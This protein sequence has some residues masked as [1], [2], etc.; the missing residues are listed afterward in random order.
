M[1]LGLLP[2]AVLCAT[3]TYASTTPS[4]TIVKRDSNS[5]PFVT[6]ADGQFQANGSEIKFVGTNAYWLSTLNTDADIDNT[7]ASIAAIGIKVVRLWAFNDV[8]TI[9]V[10]G[11]WLQLVLK[12]GT[13]LFNTGPNGIQKLDKILE[14][15]PQ[16]GLFVILSLT[17]NWNPLPLL[18]PVTTPTRRDVTQGTN[19]TL[20]R[21]FLSNDY[22]GMDLYIRQLGV[23]LTHDQFYTDQT[24]IDAFENYI[25]QIVSRYANNP[26][27][28]S[29]EI[30]N[31]PRCNS[32][33]AASS[34]CTTTTITQW[35]SIIA[36]HIR[37]IDPNHLISSGTGGFFC[38]SCPKLFPPTAP[39]PAP[40][41]S[42]VPGVTRRRRD[43]L[44]RNKVLE[45]AQLRKRNREA[46]KRAGGLSQNGI[47]I[48]G[49]WLSTP[50]RR[51]D[52]GVGPAFDGSSGVDSEDIAG[53]PEVGFLT[54]QYFPDQNN[55]GP[56]DP[57][58]SAVNNTI[59]TGI[60][61]I[62]SHIQVG[63]TFN[64]PVV[65]TAFGVVT[66]NNSQ[67]FVPFNSTTAP[68]AL[69]S[70]ADTG[71]SKAVE[72]PFGVTDDD[73][74]DIYSSVLSAGV[75]GGINGMTQY[76]WGL[77]GLTTSPGTSV[78]PADTTSSE[79]PVNTETGVSP[80]D[81][82]STEGTEDDGV[83]QVLANGAAATS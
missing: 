32:S 46:K 61:W 38:A 78:S 19:N 34:E 60:D 79:S 39:P 21:N 81:G 8:D 15:A 57:N 26:A 70:T 1:Y 3:L 23:G 69:D 29:W 53:I 2:L 36:Q 14:L 63:Q 73:R 35:H 75:N 9:P 42:A 76:Q 22:G 74:N 31:D 48:R 56:A 68:F 37:S 51:Q 77:T 27:I 58:L 71:A 41:T 10:N 80:N 7:L 72:Q 49:R 54:F 5:S 17:N 40:K 82:Y 16:H 28:F 47:K 18:D 24:L 50:E 67:A 33:L 30:A 12:N 66:Q 44:A 83:Q 4:P 13:T 20:P 25:T 6:S 65:L 52:T 62:T 59:Q 11:T 55:Y 64:K 43:V 45:Q